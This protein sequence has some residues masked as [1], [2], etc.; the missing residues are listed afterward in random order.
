MSKKPPAGTGTT[1]VRQ[2]RSAAELDDVRFLMRSF[3]AWHRE[4]H[5]AHI[6]L[7]NRYFDEAE[8]EQELEGL[9]GKYATPQ[10]SLLIAYRDQE[11]AGCVALRD[12]G[13]GIG[14]MKRM[15]VPQAH[16]GIGVGRDL[17]VRII[18][19]ARGAGYRSIRLDTSFRQAEAMRLYE[20]VG[21][22][23][24]APYYALEEDMR[25]FLVF[26]ELPLR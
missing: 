14:E 11:P 18:E 15:F 6:D 12:L 22:G 26:F 24:I 3:V 25:N 1:V 20:R 17:A 19:D 9:P 5:V 10:G 23:R 2:A 4:R 13:D 16:R 21:F 8:F 7:I